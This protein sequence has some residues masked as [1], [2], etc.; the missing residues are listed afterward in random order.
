MEKGIQIFIYQGDT[1]I[2]NVTNTENKEIMV[3]N[4]VKVQFKLT[5]G[6]S[7]TGGQNS[8]TLQWNLLPF[9]YNAIFVP[10]GNNS[11]PTFTFKSDQIV[12]SNVLSNNISSSLMNAYKSFCNITT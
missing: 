6:A 10:T 5:L 12:E 11:Q 2:G 7:D 3:E 8:A 1:I 4:P 9:F